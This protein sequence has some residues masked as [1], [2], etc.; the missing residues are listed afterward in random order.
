MKPTIK[1]KVAFDNLVGNGGNVTKAMK[2]AKYTPATYNTPQKLTESEGFKQLEKEYADSIPDELLEEKHKALLNKEDENGVIDVQ[3]V[4][5]GLDMA[6][7]LKGSYAP[8]KKVN[9]N[10]NINIEDPKAQEIAEKYEEELR[11]QI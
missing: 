5:S 9:A 3:A 7:K 8:E 6:Y 11:K 4:K 10:V 1:Q 2:D